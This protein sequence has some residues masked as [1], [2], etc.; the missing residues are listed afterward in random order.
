MSDRVSGPH[1]VVRLGRNWIDSGTLARTRSSR[2]GP[3]QPIERSEFS[4]S[5][6]R[7]Q[8]LLQDPDGILT[9][10]ASARS[11][12]A[13]SQLLLFLQ[14]LEKQIRNFLGRPALRVTGSTERWL[15]GSDSIAEKGQT[16][17]VRDPQTGR[18]LTAYD[19]GAYLARTS[20][21]SASAVLPGWNKMD[22]IEEQAVPARSIVLQGIAAPQNPGGAWAHGG[23]PLPGG[24]EQI[25]HAGQLS[26]D[27]RLL[28]PAERE[29]L[30]STRP[31]GSRIHPRT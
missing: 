25:F 20:A 15:R 16:E 11:P 29:I 4:A 26:L 21:R 1:C 17:H 22:T 6:E 18:R 31:D 30:S 8:T 3:T 27:G 9:R 5:I 24:G 12:D 7:L 14:T 28:P 13:S 19:Q 23:T 2:P 10:L